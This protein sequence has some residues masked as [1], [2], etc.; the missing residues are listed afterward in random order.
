MIQC[1]KHDAWFLHD[2]PFRYDVVLGYYDGSLD[3]IT[4]C[5]ICHQGFYY[6]LLDWDDN[7]DCRVFA[8]SEIGFTGEQI[9]ESLGI[10]HLAK[11]NGVWLPLEYS[12]KFLQNTGF[13]P[14][15]NVEQIPLE[16]RNNPYWDKFTFLPP[17]ITHLCHS[18]NSFKTGFWRKIL[19]SDIGVNNW[20]EHLGIVPPTYDDE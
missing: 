7:A 2:L 15:D 4:S 17:L 20:I 6:V 13:T 5:S 12:D 8:F 3:G 9:V 14:L 1:C 18:E 16:Y 19:P 11:R 10:K